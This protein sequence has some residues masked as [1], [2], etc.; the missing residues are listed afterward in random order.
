[1]ESIV[2]IQVKL[3]ED[4]GCGGLAGLEEVTTALPR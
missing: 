1:M 3:R 2:G 4:E